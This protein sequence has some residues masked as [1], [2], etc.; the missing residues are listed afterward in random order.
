MVLGGLMHKERD[1]LK[2]QQVINSCLTLDQLQ[3]AKKMLELYYVSY[4]PTYKDLSMHWLNKM[5]QMTAHR[6]PKP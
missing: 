2:V 5:A 3:A 1:A 4:K 6:K